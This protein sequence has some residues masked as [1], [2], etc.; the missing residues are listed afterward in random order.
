MIPAVPDTVS[1][2]GRREDIPGCPTVSISRGGLK[3]YLLEN[4]GLPLRQPAKLLL[5]AQG[6]IIV[7]LID[8]LAVVKPHV[9][10]PVEAERP[11]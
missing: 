7:A 11:P 2:S 4:S 6:V 10:D 8:D 3:Y 1:G 9:R 5:K